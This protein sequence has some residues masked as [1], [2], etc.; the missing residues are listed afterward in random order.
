MPRR[1]MTGDRFVKRC[2]KPSPTATARSKKTFDNIRERMF[3]TAMKS[4]IDSLTS[5]NAN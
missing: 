2:V 1:P 4:F 5:K 3:T